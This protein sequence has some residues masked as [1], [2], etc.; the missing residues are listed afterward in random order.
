[1]NKNL[2]DNLD[3]LN[4]SNLNMSKEIKSRGDLSI[5][6]DE[7]KKENI[8]VFLSES[9][10]DQK[11]SIIE[12]EK[13]LS[14][15]LNIREIRLFRNSSTKKPIYKNQLNDSIRSKEDKSGNINESMI[16]LPHRIEEKLNDKKT[17]E[18]NSSHTY[19]IPVS[20]PIIKEEI[21]DNEG[22]N[23][24]HNVE[25]LTRSVSNAKMVR[26]DD[27]NIP[28]SEIRSIVEVNEEEKEEENKIF[29]TNTKI[30]SDLEIDNNMEK[31][32]VIQTPNPFKRIKKK[33]ESDGKLIFSKSNLLINEKKNFNNNS[34]IVELNKETNGKLLKKLSMKKCINPKILSGNCY[35]EN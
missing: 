18:I 29:I 35:S 30:N 7:I 15:T 21:K 13:Q 20:L 28:K 27:N 23:S 3:Q 14:I 16:L 12:G 11:N 17:N 26:Q 4:I 19:I 2:D 10:L 25:L 34:T 8:E 6:E 33:N 24:N 32:Q 22:F 1:M 5:Y 31:S 9:N